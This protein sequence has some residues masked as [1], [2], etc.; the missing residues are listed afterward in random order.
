MT[1]TR[2]FLLLLLI[3]AAGFGVAVPAAVLVD[4]LP[5][6]VGALV[7]IGYFVLVLLV[8]VFAAKWAGRGRRAEYAARLKQQ[9]RIIVLACAAA[10]VVGI[11]LSN[12]AAESL[13]AL[14]W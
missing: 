4:L 12:S 14:A 7:L 1:K 8:G 3:L 9:E 2:T 10:S 13:R 6:W 11:P 5:A